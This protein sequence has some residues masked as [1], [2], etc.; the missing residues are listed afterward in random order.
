MAQDSLNMTQDGP[1]KAQDICLKSLKNQRKINILALG[2]QLGI[3][4]A[5]DGPKMAQGGPKMSQDGPKMAP[6]RPRK[7]A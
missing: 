7:Y 1:N 4:M 5:E 6:R 3:K 2:L